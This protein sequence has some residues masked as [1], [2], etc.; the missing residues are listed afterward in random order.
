MSVRVLL[1]QD[2]GFMR[3]GLKFLLEREDQYSVVAEVTSES[4]AL[5]V[6][7]AE[8]PDL[9][10][11]DFSVPQLNGVGVVAQIRQKHPQIRTVILSADDRED[12]AVMAFR[13][14]ASAIVLK[15]SS[16]AHLLKVMD[17]VSTTGSYLIL[18]QDQQLAQ[19]AHSRKAEL[20]KRNPELGRLSPREFEV[21]RLVATGQ[22]T[23]DVALTLGL[24]VQTAQSYRKTMMKKLGLNN[25]AVLTAFAIANGV[26]DT[27]TQW[28]PEVSAA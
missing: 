27:K 18:D 10:L 9:A 3:A 20:D 1:L 8:S 19:G 26:V 12:V 2:H 5:R 22:S 13:S 21:L 15:S 25:V 6:C 7:Q 17:V 14:G 28:A 4:E 23:K 16:D 24:A 11:I